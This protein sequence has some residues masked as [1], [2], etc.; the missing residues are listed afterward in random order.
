MIVWK[1]SKKKKNNLILIIINLSLYKSAFIVVN[2][3]VVFYF[4]II[5]IF[6]KI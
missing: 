2:F 5:T 1:L 4:R 3:V 6:D